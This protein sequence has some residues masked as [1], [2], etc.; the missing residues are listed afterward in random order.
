MIVIGK[1]LQVLDEDTLR[2][3][4]GT[5]LRVVLSLPAHIRGTVVQQTMLKRQP[6]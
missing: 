6:M 4:V 2:R 1:S 5:L 3:I